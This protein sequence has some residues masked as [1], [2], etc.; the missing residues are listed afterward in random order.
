[1]DVKTAYLNAPIDCEIFMEQLDGFEIPSNCEEVLVYK[2]NKSL[3]GLKQSGR[4]WNGMLHSCLLENSFLQ[5]GVDNCVYVK[6]TEDKVIVI[7]IWVDD[8]TIGASNDLLLQDTKNML[9]DKM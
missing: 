7:V 2:L 1:M 5:S 3:Y 8:L 6:Q 9:Q 4:N